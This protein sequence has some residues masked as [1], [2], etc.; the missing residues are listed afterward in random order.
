M[1]VWVMMREEFGNDGKTF[2]QKFHCTG[3]HGGRRNCTDNKLAWFFA[4]RPIG[5]R[6]GH[7]TLHRGRR[8]CRR[9]PQDP[10]GT[11]QDWLQVCRDSW[12]RETFGKG[13]SQSH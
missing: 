8:A 12:F 9:C 4:C 11:D 10:E 7:S 6:P 5:P 2:A 3:Q 1:I 13:F